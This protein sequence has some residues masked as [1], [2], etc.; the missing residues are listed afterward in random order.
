MRMFAP[1]GPKKPV[2]SVAAKLPD[3]LLAGVATAL[4]AVS[5]MG[6]WFVLVM[7]GLSIMNAIVPA[8]L[9]RNVPPPSAAG[10]PIVKAGP[11]FVPNPAAMVPAVLT[12]VLTML[13]LLMVMLESFR[14]PPCGFR[15]SI[16]QG[17]G[18]AV[19]LVPTPVAGLY[20]PDSGE[21]S[22]SSP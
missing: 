5:L 1:V 10:S 3:G 11:P 9:A 14:R 17:T 21:T 16:V 4:R 13:L 18:A 6:N 22:S 2:T 7:I 8:R 12:A 15:K 20:V 19:W